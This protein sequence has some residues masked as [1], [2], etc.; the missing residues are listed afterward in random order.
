MHSRDLDSVPNLE[1]VFGILSE[2]FV[3]AMTSQK[4]IGIALEQAQDRINRILF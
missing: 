4:A 1:Q 3:A 2:E